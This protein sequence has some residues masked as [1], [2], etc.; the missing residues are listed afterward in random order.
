MQRT[1]KGR[2]ALAICLCFVC[3]ALLSSVYIA[4]ET[5]HRCE[6]EHCSVCTRIHAAQDLL[7]QLGAGA[8]ACA[9]V[10]ASFVIKLAAPVLVPP[11]VP[12]PTPVEQKIRL[13]I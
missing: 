9:L 2:L 7:K 11:A 3:A 6:G 12:Y 13:N 1:W 5:D 10:L 8:A 4:V